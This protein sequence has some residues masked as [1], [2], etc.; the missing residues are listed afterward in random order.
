[1]SH[2]SNLKE[3]VSKVEK[4]VIDYSVGKAIGISS[5]VHIETDAKYND[6]VRFKFW[7]TGII[8]L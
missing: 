8:W 2:S 1:M 3:I 6:L 4:K 5:S 7:V